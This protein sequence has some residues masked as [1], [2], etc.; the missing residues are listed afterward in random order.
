MGNPKQYALL[1]GAKAVGNGAAI[2]LQYDTNCSFTV[3]VSGTFVASIVIQGLSGSNWF[4]AR[5]VDVTRLKAVTSITQPGIYAVVIPNAFTNVRASIDSYTSGEVTVNG[6][7][8]EG[9]V[10]ILDAAAAL[11]AQFVP[12]G[13]KSITENG[14]A[15]VY[16]Y[17]K[18]NVAVPLPTG[19]I[20][21]T[22]N[23][24]DINVYDYA[25]AT[26]AVP[27]NFGFAAAPAITAV[28][29]DNSEGAEALEIAF[30]G[31]IGNTN[32]VEIAAIGT[33]TIAAG[34]TSGTFT[35]ET[36]AEGTG[37]IYPGFV[38][39][40]GYNVTAVDEGAVGMAASSGVL[41]ITGAAPS[42]DS[43]TLQAAV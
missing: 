31:I 37:I 24:T 30:L 22:E 26:V 8:T 2:A 40:N 20:E 42:A 15:N 3:S 21:I 36:L 7:L 38:K 14:E 41:K 11:Q 27:D 25:T 1:K 13:T 23:G 10:D 29:C 4:D 6:M 32:G 5:L 18:V 16:D 33:A 9:V 39:I 35:A 12:E 43:I 34:A 28:N 19:N 17:E